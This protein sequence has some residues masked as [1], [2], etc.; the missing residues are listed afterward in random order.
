MDLFVPN[1]NM[2]VKAVVKSFFGNSRPLILTE[3][4][5]LTLLI[6]GDAFPV[7]GASW[8]QMS[9]TVV[10]HGALAREMAYT[11]LLGVAWCSDHDTESLAR[12]WSHNFQVPPHLLDCSSQLHHPL[13]HC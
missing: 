1:Q 13:I 6:R 3:D 12:I 8:T 5:P 10:N 9:I 4:H 2:C 11:W 7:A